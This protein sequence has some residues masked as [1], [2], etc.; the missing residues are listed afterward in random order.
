MINRVRRFHFT[1]EIR[2]ENWREM[3]L[4]TAR[5]A[6]GGVLFLTG[7]TG[8]TVRNQRRLPDPKRCRT[9]YLGRAIDFSKCLM[10]DPVSCQYAVLI[11]SGVICSHPD[12]RRFEKT[13][14]R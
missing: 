4:K 10:E 11:S 5:L 6:I 7:M 13:K 14:R 8:K 3:R 1:V 12:R 9:K 2:R